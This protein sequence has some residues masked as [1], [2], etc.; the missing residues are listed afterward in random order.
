[1]SLVYANDIVIFKESKAE[2]I[3]SAFKPLES[4]RITRLGFDENK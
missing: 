4:I 1:M 3:T 2:L